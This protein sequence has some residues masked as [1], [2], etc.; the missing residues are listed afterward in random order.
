MTPCQVRQERLKFVLQDTDF[1]AECF[2]TARED[3]LLVQTR[4]LFSD[5][6]CGARILQLVLQDSPPLGERP[7]CLFST[8]VARA[9]SL[10]LPPCPPHGC[11]VSIT[12]LF[13]PIRLGF[14]SEA[15]FE[16]RIS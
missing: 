16:C 13:F 2:G 8:V 12:G 5:D 10:A 15:F 9:E 6:Q 14:G 11:R 3:R 4:V 1:G 7:G